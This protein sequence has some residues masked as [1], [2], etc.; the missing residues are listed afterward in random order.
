VE[1]ETP[2][3][4]FKLLDDEFLFT[5]DPAASHDN[6]K[7]NTYFTIDDDGL[8]QSW[9]SHTIWVN[10]PYGRRVIYP[11]VDKAMRES[12]KGATIVMLLPARTDTKWYQNIVLPLAAEIR[13]VDGRLHFI[14]HSEKCGCASSDPVHDL[15]AAP[16]PSIVVVFRKPR[17]YERGILISSQPRG[18][19]E[20][21]TAD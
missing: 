12:R 4:F 8:K 20:H 5:L 15:G 1:R 18:G 21:K 11:W 17:P 14:G 2:P 9:D 6:H 19:S 13:F 16:F 3:E 7:C 10:P